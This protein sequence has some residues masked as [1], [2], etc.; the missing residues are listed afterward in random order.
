[1]G[2]NIRSW[3]TTAA[4]NSTADSSINW[5]E[6]Q[7][8]STVNDSARS[9]MA[10]LAKHLSD[11]EGALVTTGGTTAYLLTSSTVYTA[12]ASGLTLCIKFNAAN[13]GASTLNVDGLGAKSIRKFTSGA[14]GAVAANDLLANN[15]YYLVYDTAV[16]AAAGGWILLNPST[17]GS[18]T[19]AANSIDN[20][21]IAQM[22]NGTVKARVT[23]GTGNAEDATVTSILDN[24]FGSTQGTILYRGSSAWAALATGV[25]GTFLKTNGAGA[26]PSWATPAAGSG[27]VTSVAGGTYFNFTTITATGTIQLG[28]M[29]G[30]SRLLGSPSS[31]STIGDVTLGTGLSMSSAVLSN[32]GVTS[33]VAGTGISVSGATGAVTITNTAPDTLTLATAQNTTS[34]TTVDFT[35]IPSGTKRITIAINGW[36]H[37]SGSNNALLIQIGSGSVDTTGYLSAASVTLASSTTNAAAFTTGFAATTQGAASVVLHGIITLQHVGSNI[38]VMSSVLGSNNTVA[39]YAG[40]G[41]KTLAGALD[42]VRITTDLGAT[43]DAG[44]VNVLYE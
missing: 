5:A 39:T 23:A 19:I 21:L 24:A 34:G 17:V 42:R 37:S 36:S 41:N 35:S 13:T 8:P 10:T 28:S 27:T 44:S 12:L 33:A 29:G 7:A 30:S 15:H 26:N 32:S 18:T 40:G 14:E 16:N 43:F 22:A 9:M 4:T 20:T 3:S 6:G 38:W 31:G 11:T 1:M 25:S 2:E